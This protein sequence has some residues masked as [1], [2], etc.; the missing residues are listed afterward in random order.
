MLSGHQRGRG[1]RDFVDTKLRDDRFETAFGEATDREAD[2]DERI[3]RM[4]RS[5]AERP[6]RGDFDRRARVKVRR[7]GIHNRLMS[8]R[9][10]LV[11]VA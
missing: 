1:I 5:P 8:D 2:F 6:H 4:E 10:F 3:G 11:F 7:G 9:P